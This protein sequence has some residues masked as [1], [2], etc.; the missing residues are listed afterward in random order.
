ME[1]SPEAF[2]TISEVAAWLDTPAHV[3]RFWES[4]FSQ[5]KPVKRAGGRRYYRPA[6]MMLLGGIK[7][8]L[9]EDGLTIRGVQK[10]L[11]EEGVKFVSALSP[12]LEEGTPGLLIEGHA[13]PVEAVAEAPLPGDDSPVEMVEADE[14]PM[15]E[16]A[17]SEAAE[18]LPL[19]FR[20]R[21]EP[22]EA[23]LPGLDLA[24]G[25]RPAPEAEAAIPSFRRH[26]R[27]TVEE[28]PAA[29]LPFEAAPETSAEEPVADLAE[30]D[31]LLGPEP[32][33]AQIVVE[34]E[35]E[36]EPEPEA[37]APAA[38]PAEP[39]PEAEASEQAGS[40][41]L[42]EAAP[43]FEAQPEAEP[44][45]EPLAEPMAE[46][47]APAIARPLGT[48]IARSDPAD[49]DPAFAPVAPPLRTLIRTPA[50]RQ[51][52]AADRDRAGQ[53]LARLQALG[54]RMVSGGQ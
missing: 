34:P 4:R 17:E 15:Q 54:E 31:L 23:I 21:P 3:L 42:S 2:R 43:E 44:E 41:I 6:D 16:D 25:A 18:I 49:D 33:V 35:P 11:R 29:T 26:P 28:E 36:P 39:E 5:V 22:D 30:A 46:P 1:K 9:H 37:H 24:A 27:P 7:R 38:G 48:G 13:E 10:I 12:P 52:L 8:L 45:P 20:P 50:L 47:P 19:A 14:A 32:E 53:S 51:A 40:D